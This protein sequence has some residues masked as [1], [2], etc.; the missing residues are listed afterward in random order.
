MPMMPRIVTFAPPTV[1][2]DLYKS[3]MPFVQGGGVFVPSEDRYSLGDQCLLVL[4]VPDHDELSIVSYVV[5]IVPTST[6]PLGSMRGGRWTRGVGL[7]FTGTEGVQARSLIEKMLGR[8]LGS[9]QP[10]FT[11]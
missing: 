5:W 1:V 8:Q 9:T 7:R 4:K 3:Y 2:P 11:F 10:T 6:N